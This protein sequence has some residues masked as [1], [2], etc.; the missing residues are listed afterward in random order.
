MKTDLEKFKLKGFVKKRQEIGYKDI[1]DN[2]KPQSSTLFYKDVEIFNI[3][4]N[5]TE[6]TEYMKDTEY[7]RDLLDEKYYYKYNKQGYIDE[8]SSDINILKKY[9]YD[10]K[11]RLIEFGFIRGYESYK[12]DNN[13]NLIETEVYVDTQAGY[14]SEPKYCLKTRIVNKVDKVGNILEKNRYEL[15]PINERELQP[16]RKLRDSKTTYKYDEVGNL[17]EEV[18]FNQDGIMISKELYK[19]DIRLGRL[20][21]KNSISWFINSETRHL[22]IYDNVPNL[23]EEQHYSHD[24]LLYSK[25][26]YK[27]DNIGNIIECSEFNFKYENEKVIESFVNFIETQY[28]YYE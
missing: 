19:Y 12:Y 24:G 9:T 8:V 13:D 4:G 18:Y 23:K 10:S 14:F 1:T 11:N 16:Q 2:T 28:E 25:I 17:L 3:N 26:I 20:I 15:N 6:S 27:H 21:E 22:Y 7:M 5:L